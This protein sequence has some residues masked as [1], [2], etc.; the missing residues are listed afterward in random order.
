[1]E[2]NEKKNLPAQFLFSDIYENPQNEIS[3]FSAY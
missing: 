1:M 2:K 3:A